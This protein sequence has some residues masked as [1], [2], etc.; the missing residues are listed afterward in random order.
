MCY[1]IWA[2]DDTSNTKNLDYKQKSQHFDLNI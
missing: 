1:W 2:V